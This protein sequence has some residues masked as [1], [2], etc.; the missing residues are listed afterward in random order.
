MTYQTYADHHITP[1]TAPACCPECDIGDGLCAYPYYGMAPH[2]YVTAPD[3]NGRVS[4]ELPE[5]EWPE[6]FL[7]D[8]EC[9]PADG[10]PRGGVYTHCLTCGRPGSRYP[11]DLVESDGG[12]A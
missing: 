8:S 5:A 10:T 1:R 9:E 3:T 2:G 12:E 4:V 6:N 11:N 7:L